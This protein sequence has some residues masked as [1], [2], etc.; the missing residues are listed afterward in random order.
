MR[1]AVC[2]WGKNAQTRAQG[3][4]PRKWTRTVSL[5]GS[6]ERTA[7]SLPG[8][9]LPSIA[10]RRA[11]SRLGHSRGAENKS[12]LKNRDCEGSHLDFPD[13]DTWGI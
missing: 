11:I 1:Q 5:L 7:T 10:G 13:A 8:L 6:R 4:L 9:S 3:H 12:P 2:K